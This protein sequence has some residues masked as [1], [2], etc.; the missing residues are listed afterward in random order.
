VEGY[1]P[2]GTPEYGP[3]TPAYG[4]TTPNFGPTTPTFPPEEPKGGYRKT[5]HRGRSTG[6]TR[7]RS[8][9]IRRYAQQFSS[10]WKIHATNKN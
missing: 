10:L 6:V 2:E 9:P 4:P 8:N 7:K 3:S 5:R 1:T